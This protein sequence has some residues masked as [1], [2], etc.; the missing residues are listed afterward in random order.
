MK[1]SACRTVIAPQMSAP[2]EAVAAQVRVLRQRASLVC[3]RSCCPGTA[4]RAWMMGLI[5]KNLKKEEKPQHFYVQTLS[6]FC[7]AAHQTNEFGIVFAW[8][9]TSRFHQVMDHSCTLPRRCLIWRARLL[10][11]SSVFTWVSVLTHKA[12]AETLANVL[13]KIL[14]CEGYSPSHFPDWLALQR[15]MLPDYYSAEEFHQFHSDR[16]SLHRGWDFKALVNLFYF[17][18]IVSESLKSSFPAGQ[19]AAFKGRVKSS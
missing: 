18:A 19:V 7:S 2:Q 1:T 9:W 8:V 4:A 3:S 13:C 17:I 6:S 12:K 10:L 11:W 16:S 5:F 15:L 14:G